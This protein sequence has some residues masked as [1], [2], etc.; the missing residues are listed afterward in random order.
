MYIRCW[1]GKAKEIAT[2]LQ[3]RVK[4]E[5]VH[6]VYL[7]E[8]MFNC[9]RAMTDIYKLIC[10]LSDLD[11]LLKQASEPEGGLGGGLSHPPLFLQS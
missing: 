6:V 11:G 5:Q 1:K 4:H 8:R 9:Q 7:H 3:I 2:S 10:H